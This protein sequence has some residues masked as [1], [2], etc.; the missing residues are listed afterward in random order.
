VIAL[1][2]SCTIWPF[3]QDVVVG[4]LGHGPH[5][6]HGVDLLAAGIGQ[7]FD[8]PTGQSIQQGERS[9]AAA[10]TPRHAPA[11]SDPIADKRHGVIHQRRD[12]QLAIHFHDGAPV[13]TD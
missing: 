10:L 5:E 8:Y 6:V 9:P 12:G 1:S 11:I 13:R 4:L 3:F 2:S 7:H